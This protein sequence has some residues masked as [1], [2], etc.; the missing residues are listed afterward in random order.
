MPPQFVMPVND[1]AVVPLYWQMPEMPATV[2]VPLVDGNASADAT[3]S[4]PAARF[5]LAPLTVVVAGGAFTVV[6][7]VTVTVALSAAAPL[8]PL[9][10][11]ITPGTSGTPGV[12]AS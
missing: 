4:V 8:Q 6:A 3:F 10:P 2:N 11:V 9:M 1:V 5:W 7:V 12:A